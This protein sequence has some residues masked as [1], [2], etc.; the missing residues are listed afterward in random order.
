MKKLKVDQT[1]TL[2]Y[3]VIMKAMNSSSRPTGGWSQG[4]LAAMNN[5]EVV[6]D[7]DD[8]LVVIKDKYPKAL[9]HFLVLPKRN[10]PN[11]KSLTQKDLELL[12]HIHKKGEEIANRANKELR[13][14]LGY[15]AVP[16]MSHLHMH[17][18]SQDF[19]SPCLKNKKH[20]NSFNT[21]YFI[22]SVDLIREIEKTGHWKSDQAEMNA[23]LKKDLRC[24]VCKEV[25]QT[26]PSLKAHI[27]LH[28]VTK[29]HDS[30]SS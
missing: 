6:I 19:N 25:F 12:K 22:D 15:H 4:L 23:F 10:I 13:F 5:P 9:F 16:S 2:L 8:Q 11:L 18:I 1:T 28:D 17:V 29:H 14:R 20:W 26:I 30:S 27:S 24:H 21:H 3:Q 7:S